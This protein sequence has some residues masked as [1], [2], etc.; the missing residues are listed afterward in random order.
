MSNRTRRR[1]ASSA[2]PILLF[3]VCAAPALANRAATSR[4]RRDIARVVHVRAG[5][6]T[7]RVSTVRTSTRWAVARTRPCANAD[8]VIGLQRKNNRWRARFEGPNDPTSPCE[9]FITGVPVTVARDLAM[10]D[11]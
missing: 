11:A 10:C 9:D 1:L 8:G 7:V 5:C 6:L 4:E 2:V 3:G